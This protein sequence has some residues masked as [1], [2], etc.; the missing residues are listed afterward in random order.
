MTSGRGGAPRKEETKSLLLSVAYEQK[1]DE[2]LKRVANRSA[3]SVSAYI[4][5]VTLLDMQQQGLLDADF[6]P[7]PDEPTQEKKV[8]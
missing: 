1:Y 4:R 2:V 8:S 3:R 5:W 7:V 6:E